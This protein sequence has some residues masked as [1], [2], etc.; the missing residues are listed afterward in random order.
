MEEAK[1]TGFW[2]RYFIACFRPSKYGA[3]LG[4]KMMG[5]VGY[6]CLLVAFIVFVESVI[7]FAAW[8]V[9]VGGFKNL[10]LNRIPAFTL[11]GGTM[12][13]ETPIEFSVGNTLRVSVDSEVENYGQKDLDENY[14]EEILISQGNLLMKAANRIYSLSFHEVKDMMVNNESLARAIPVLHMMT[15]IFFV[16]SYGTRLVQYLI[17]AAFFALLCHVGVRKEDGKAITFKEVFLIAVYARTL[18]AL[19]ESV[20][21]C[22]GSLVSDILLIFLSAMVTMSYIYR[23]EAELL[24]TG[25]M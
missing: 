10:I 6:V 21:L 5:H 9:S 11:S 2:Q 20:N 14:A 25:I 4:R 19:L 3:L 8:D 15:G 23:A 7:P 17:T 13:I 12:E 16:I 1:Q 18:F 24:K 22:L